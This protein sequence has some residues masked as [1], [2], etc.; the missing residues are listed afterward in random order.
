MDNIA[1]VSQSIKGIIYNI[2]RFTIHDGPGIRTE[3]FMKGCPMRCKW[4]SNPESSNPKREQGFYPS[5]C[6]GY[7]KCGLCVQACPLSP[8]SPLVVEQ[9]AIVGTQGTKCI[10]CFECAKACPPHAVMVWGEEMTVEQVMDIVLADVAFYKK[11]GGGITLSG[12]EVMMQWKFALELLKACKERYIHTCVESALLCD[13]DALAELFPYTDLLITDI[14]HM[15]PEKHREFTGA[16][17][18][19]ILS[20]IQRTIERCV[21]L[22][23]RIPVIP[24]YNNCEDNIR[25]TAEFIS[26]VLHNKVKQVQLLPYWKMGTEKYASLGLPYPMGDDYVP[27]R[28]KSAGGKYS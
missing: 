20:N 11:S 17:N 19:V 24:D 14:K 9:N 16:S 26:N 1:L 25:A 2:Q 18:R 15:D 28:A 4:C 22:V 23:I 8:D 21:P 10:S 12:G 7:D 27:A 6:V 3:V 5:R 13:P